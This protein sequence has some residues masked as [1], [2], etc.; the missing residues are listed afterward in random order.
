MSHLE[1]HDRFEVAEAPRLPGNGESARARGLQWTLLVDSIAASG[2]GLAGCSPKVQAE[3]RELAREEGTLALY[4]FDGLFADHHGAIIDA[5]FERF[6]G[7]SIADAATTRYPG[8]FFRSVVRRE[9]IAWTE[10]SIDADSAATG[11]SKQE[12]AVLVTLQQARLKALRLRGLPRRIFLAICALDGVALE[13]ETAKVVLFGGVAFGMRR[14]TAYQHMS[15]VR[16]KLF[17]ELESDAWK[18][19]FRYLVAPPSAV[20][21]SA[22]EYLDACQAREA[23]LERWVDAHK[24]HNS[25]FNTLKKRSSCAALSW[26]AFAAALDACPQKPC[27]VQASLI[28]E[29]RMLGIDAQVVPARLATRSWRDLL[30]LVKRPTRRGRAAWSEF[31]TRNA[32]G[33][34]VLLAWREFEAQGVLAEAATKALNDAFDALLAAAGDRPSSFINARTE[35]RSLVDNQ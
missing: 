27:A 20:S 28:A 21:L 34:A 13:G 1:C 22:R 32:F 3:A 19:A 9:A 6:C 8:A 4:S 35:F 14:S 24:T 18:H 10:Q 31:L 12:R 2:G 26:R 33:A 15:R 25:C 16:R 11:L 23:G 5:A 30:H 17:S 7:D 29:S